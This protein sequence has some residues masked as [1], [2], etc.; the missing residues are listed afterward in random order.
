MTQ[1]IASAIVLLAK[2][3]RMG[4]APLVSRLD[5]GFGC[6]DSQRAR[7]SSVTDHIFVIVAGVLGPS[8]K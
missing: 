4:V 3:R 8:P 1:L 5:V 7:N 2:L 6:K